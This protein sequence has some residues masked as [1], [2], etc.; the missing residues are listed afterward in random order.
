MNTINSL[1]IEGEINKLPDENGKF[2]I[3]T[4]RHSK[5]ENGD[6]VDTTSHFFVVAGGGLLDFVKKHYQKGRGIRIVGRLQNDER[7]RAEILAEHIE[8]KPCYIKA[9]SIGA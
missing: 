5:N 4:V 9:E 2:Y 7:G 3:K 8:Y 6:F 1:I